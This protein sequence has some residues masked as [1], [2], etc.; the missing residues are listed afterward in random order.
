MTKSGETHRLEKAII[1]DMD[2]I[3]YARNIL[4]PV[5]KIKRFLG[6]NTLEVNSTK[7]VTSKILSK[8]DHKNKK[9]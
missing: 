8:L 6:I 5:A 3:D 1:Q 4:C 9:K 7:N 2:C